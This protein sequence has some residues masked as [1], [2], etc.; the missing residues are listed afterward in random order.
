VNN[1]EPEIDAKAR[2]YC[3]SML[4]SSWPQAARWASFYIVSM[5]RIEH[6]QLGSM[7]FGRTVWLSNWLVLREWGSTGFL[8]LQ[9]AKGHSPSVVFLRNVNGLSLQE[10]RGR[11]ASMFHDFSLPGV[12][13]FR[14]FW[15]L[16]EFF[17]SL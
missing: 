2:V 17:N 10:V 12:E 9:V 13:G 1:V 15:G 8:Y 6:Q 3:S 5:G 7:W 14:L 4:G 11:V 16:V